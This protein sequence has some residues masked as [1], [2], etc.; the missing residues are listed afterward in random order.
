MAAVDGGGYAVSSQNHIGTLLDYLLIY[1]IHACSLLNNC[2]RLLL[3]N[4]FYLIFDD[5]ILF[6]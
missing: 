1:I 4:S 2:I 6:I 5:L 3:I